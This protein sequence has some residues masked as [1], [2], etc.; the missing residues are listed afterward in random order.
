MF[1]FP[2]FRLVQPLAA[3]PIVHR[4]LLRATPALRGALLGVFALLGSTGAALAQSTPAHSIIAKQTDTETLA[5]T[6]ANP[7]RERMRVQVTHEENQKC[8]LD[9]V[10]WDE[11]YGCRLRFGN[12]SAGQYTVQVRVGHEKYRYHVQVQSQVPGTISVREL[13][14]PDAEQ[15]VASVAK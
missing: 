9:D 1:H 7:A 4:Q 13:A 5:F 2:T 11:S 12:L 3:T 6:V 14:T 8:L 15:T 10:S